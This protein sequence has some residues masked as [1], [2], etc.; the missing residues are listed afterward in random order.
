MVYGGLLL[1]YLS[2]SSPFRVESTY[3]RTNASFR[4]LPIILNIQLI[5]TWLTRENME[6]IQRVSLILW[7]GCILGIGGVFPALLLG[8]FTF[9]LSAL[10]K[11]RNT[12][13]KWLDGY[14]LRYYASKP[15]G[16]QQAKRLKEW[17]ESV[18]FCCVV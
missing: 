18:W 17:F 8:V 16:I 14:S 10:T 11:L 7:C 12:N 6:I 2:K 13:G 1:V 9:F 15:G 5:K 4:Q 3:F